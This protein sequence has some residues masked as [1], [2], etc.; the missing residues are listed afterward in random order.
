M[1]LINKANINTQLITTV[2]EI[3][4]VTS[5]STLEL[6]N[7]FTHVTSVFNLPTDSSIYP[8]RY[9]SFV[10]PTTTFSALTNNIYNYTIKDS[11]SGITETGILK[12]IAEEL[13][14][15][16]LVDSLYTYITPAET[17]DDYVVY[18]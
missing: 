6:F 14:E 1:L 8:T 13:T 4:A 3:N 10:L 5:G 15:E 11:T 16:E 9:N 7:V 17:D 2:S 18:E 12:V